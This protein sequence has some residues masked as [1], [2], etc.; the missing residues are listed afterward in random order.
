MI[1]LWLGTGSAGKYFG[2]RLTAIP[3]KDPHLASSVRRL[4]WSCGGR[5]LT[6]FCPVRVKAA[7]N[8]GARSVRDWD[9]VNYGN[10]TAG[11][12]SMYHSDWVKLLGN[13]VR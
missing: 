7:K 8:I 13:K 3:R 5:C 11:S 4:A 6:F 9:N 2:S 12:V 10:I 1:I